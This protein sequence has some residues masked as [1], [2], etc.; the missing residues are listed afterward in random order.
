[1]AGVDNVQVNSS[2]GRDGNS[3]TTSISNDKLTN[4]DF[5]KLMLEELKMQDPTKPMDSQRMLDSQMQMSSIE[6]NL[7]LVK[8]MDTL[9]SSYAQSA[10]SNAAN[11]IGKNIED[12]NINDQGINKAYTVRSVVNEDGTV[13]VKAQ[14]ILFLEQ[15]IKDKDDKLINYNTKGEIIGEDGEPTG[16]KVTLTAPGQV[17]LKD[18]KPIIL[19]K[20]NNPV[21]DHEYKMAGGSMPVYSDKLSELPFSAI[22]KIF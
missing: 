10:L 14:E 20:D 5:L 17:A 6:T 22:T 9:T 1:M 21:E 12:G 13:L 3:Y 7:Q 15:Q 11:V 16:Q 2:V 18:G 19:D 4:Q 8:S